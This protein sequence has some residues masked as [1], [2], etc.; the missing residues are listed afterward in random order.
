MR[1]EARARAGSALTAGPV[2]QGFG[3]VLAADSLGLFQI[4]EGTRHLEQAVR[5][6]QRQ[7]Q[8]FAGALQP[9]LILGAELAMA[10]QAGEVEEGI[11]AALTGELP[12]SG[13][14]YLGREY[15]PA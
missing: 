7:R 13:L 3:E 10:A 9:G 5:G 12:L 14:G 4:G 11:G 1:T 8:A 15:R 6:A 2:L